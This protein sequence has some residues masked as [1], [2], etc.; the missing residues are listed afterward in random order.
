MWDHDESFAAEE[1]ER[2]AA[3][4][5]GAVCLGLALIVLLVGAVVAWAFRVGQR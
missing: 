4:V 2:A 3:G 1:L 5:C